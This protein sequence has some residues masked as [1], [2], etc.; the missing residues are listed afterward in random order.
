VAQF[1]G[2]IV[3]SRRVAAGD[4]LVDEPLVAGEVRKVPAAPQDQVLLRGVLGA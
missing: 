3:P 2:E 1:H 4:D